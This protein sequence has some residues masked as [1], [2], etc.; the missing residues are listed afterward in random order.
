MGSKDP[1]TDAVAPGGGEAESGGS[2][3][4]RTII[5][6]MSVQFVALLLLWLLQRTYGA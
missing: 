1:S 4:R 3:F 5:R 6:V 2:R